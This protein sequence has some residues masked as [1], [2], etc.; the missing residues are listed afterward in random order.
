MD[1]LREDDGHH[2]GVVHPQGHGRALP[3]VGLA[4]DDALGVLVLNV[5]RKEHKERMDFTGATEITGIC[6]AYNDASPNR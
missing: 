1:G 6:L 5:C 2:A 4:A 3:A